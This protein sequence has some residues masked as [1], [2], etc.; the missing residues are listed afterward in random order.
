MFPG[1]MFPRTKAACLVLTFLLLRS[2]KAEEAMNELY[3]FRTPRFGGSGKLSSLM[4]STTPEISTT[5]SEKDR[6]DKIVERSFMI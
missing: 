6:E 1:E 3:L 5:P 4:I 2:D